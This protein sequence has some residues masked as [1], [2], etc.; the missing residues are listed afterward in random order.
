MTLQWIQ[1]PAVVTGEGDE[2][3]FEYL[4]T[5]QS[6]HYRYTV[7]EIPGGGVLGQG[8]WMTTVT[9]NDHQTGGGWLSETL[10]EAKQRAEDHD[11][12]Q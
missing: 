9:A 11:A 1:T 10:D 3:L 2:L 12:A 4:W 7:S 8:G 5:A 6:Q